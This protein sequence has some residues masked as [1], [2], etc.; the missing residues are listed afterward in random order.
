MYTYK[1]A[2][3]RLQGLV[4]GGGGEATRAGRHRRDGDIM[5]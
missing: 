4:L 5:L 1:G 2:G 3:R